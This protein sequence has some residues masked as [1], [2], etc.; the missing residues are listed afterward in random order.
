MLEREESDTER[1]V[2]RLGDVKDVETKCFDATG[3]VAGLL[4]GEAVAHSGNDLHA[5]RVVNP[6]RWGPSE[7]SGPIVEKRV[8]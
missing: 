5:L 1:V 7:T 8:V 3:I 2:D 6:D 4:E